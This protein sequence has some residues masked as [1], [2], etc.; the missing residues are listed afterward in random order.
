MEKINTTTFPAG[1]VR[2]KKP[3]AKKNK[4]G[5]YTVTFRFTT[6]PKRRKNRP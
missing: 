5:T 3:L 1:T 2:A 6:K 4:D